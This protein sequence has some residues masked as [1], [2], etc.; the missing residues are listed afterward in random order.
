MPDR[1]VPTA[2][3]G[4]PAALT[5]VLDDVLATGAALAAADVARTRALAAAGH[6]ALD[7][8]AD[9]RAAARAAELALREVASEIAAA[10]NL[11]DRTVQ[12]QIGRA[13]TLVDHY[14][15][16]LAAW[17]AGAITRAHV[18]AIV[19][20]GTPLPVEARTEFDLLAVA[21]ADGLS[22]GR[23][24]ARL[25]VLAE[26]LHPTTITERHH[27][28]RDTRCVRIVTGHDGMSD[29]I[30]TLPTVLAVGIYDRLTQQSRAIIDTRTGITAAL[31][32]TP[33]DPASD[34]DA[35]HAHHDTEASRS[36]APRSTVATERSDRE[37]GTASV[38]DERTTAQLR[39][40]ILAD[41]LLTAA[42]TADPTRTDDGPGT[43]GT[44]RARI[45]VIV[46]A[47]TMLKPGAENTDP[48]ELVGHGPLDAATARTLAEATTLPWDRVITHPITGA[49]LHTDTYHRTTAIDRHLR[50][51]DRTCRFPGCTT[52]A[53]RCEVDHTHD[54]AH[55]G[56]TTITNLAHLCQRHH[57]QKHLT[58]WQVKQLPDEVL[59][60]TS[61]T[62]RT[63]TDEPLP[64][65]PAT[66][67]LPDDPP[68]PDPEQGP[69]PF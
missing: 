17:E 33:A 4:G 43:L 38:T 34:S 23:L 29:L 40:D 44:I 48:A 24:R 46:P 7:V 6:L 56:P 12:T 49:V 1:I 68:P 27:R 58:R 16:T 14:P 9:Q 35:N 41:L 61:P 11:S 51:R 36:A 63:Y 50:A 54:H 39:A 66:R 69:P 28:G 55:G 21:T 45:Q 47:L 65:S 53:T 22:P 42:P 57:T 15:H 13:M 64:Y 2:P 26:R 32:D 25:A 19:D 30:A 8:M 59:K 5:A 3:K 37:A 10:E 62:G 67:F 52:P 18:H 60:W 20:I 31:A